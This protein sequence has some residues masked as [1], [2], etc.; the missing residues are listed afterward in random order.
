MVL[1][2]RVVVLSCCPS[3][4]AVARGRTVDPALPHM[5][6]GYLSRPNV[7]CLFV[8]YLWAGEECLDSKK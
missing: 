5:V 7:K 6:D 2:T 8:E 1:G 4:G 3:K